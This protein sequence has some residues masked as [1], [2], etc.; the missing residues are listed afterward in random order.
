MNQMNL[1]IVEGNLVREPEVKNLENIQ[2]TVTVFTIAQH[3]CYVNAKK[4]IV[5]DT[6]FIDVEVWGTG[7]AEKI[8]NKMKKGVLA[9]VQGSIKQQTWSDVDGKRHQKHI[10]Q[11]N[12][13][14]FGKTEKDDDFDDDLIET[15]GVEVIDC[16]GE[17]KKEA[18]RRKAN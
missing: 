13:V 11:A 9:R 1:C 17:D 10:V 3:N 4:E 12:S 6:N 8:A 5:D 14:N 7:F 15:I 16:G 2:K 18:K